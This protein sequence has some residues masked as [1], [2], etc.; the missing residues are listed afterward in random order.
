MS[1][2]LDCNCDEFEKCLKILNLIL[3]NE[4]TPSQEEYFKSHIEKCSICFA[5]CNMEKQIRQLIKTKM[6]NKS[7]PNALAN[8]IRGKI[9]R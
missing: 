6:S 2:C 4:A 9:V 5:H 1:D 8:E 3:D 7:V